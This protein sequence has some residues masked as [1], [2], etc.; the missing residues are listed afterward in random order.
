MV[1]RLVI[2]FLL[3]FVSGLLLGMVLSPLLQACG[4]PPRLRVV[5]PDIEPYSLVT[6]QPCRCDIFPFCSGSV[7]DVLRRRK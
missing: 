5:P 2:G 7:Y 4:V 6:S 3:C 1:L